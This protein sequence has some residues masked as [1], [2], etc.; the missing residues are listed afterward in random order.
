ME[1]ERKSNGAVRYDV[2]EYP[3]G[4]HFSI[5]DKE[6]SFSVP[7]PTNDKQVEK[8][9]EQLEHAFFLTG[10]DLC[11]ELDMSPELLEMAWEETVEAPDSNELTPN[12]L[13]ELVHSHKATPLEKYEA[14]R[15]LRSE[16][17]HVFFKELKEQGRVVS[18]KP[19]PKKS[20]DASK[21]SYC[22]SHSDDEDIC[23]A[24]A[25]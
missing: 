14:W 24:V 5:A 23:N 6:V 9:L 18:F 13:V 19:K 16:V 12:D 8:L 4:K 15:L 17:G 10:R 22:A 7:P 20:V 3:S 21:D 2:E 11:K 1:V 25:P